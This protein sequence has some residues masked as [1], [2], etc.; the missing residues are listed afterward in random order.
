M[1]LKKSLRNLIRLFAGQKDCRAVYYV[2]SRF[3]FIDFIN[4]GILKY[5]VAFDVIYISLST[6]PEN[7][8]YYCCPI[9][10]K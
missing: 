10:L 4:L 8:S 2:E 1:K 7:I 9:K 5:E 6:L 3:Q